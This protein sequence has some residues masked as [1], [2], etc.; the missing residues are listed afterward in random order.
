MIELNEWHTL[1]KMFRTPQDVHLAVEILKNKELSE[2]DMYRV[3][4]LIRGFDLPQEARVTKNPTW[5]LEEKM[6]KDIL[7][8]FPWSDVV[9]K[10]IEDLGVNAPLVNS[11]YITSGLGHMQ[12]FPISVR[13]TQNA[14]GQNSSGCGERCVD[15]LLGR[16]SQGSSNDEESGG[17]DTI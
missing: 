5:S 11:Q 9:T 14:S 4:F 2:L 6:K 8:H 15:A 7:S 12:S 17:P 1:R 10:G 13:S 3:L 16:Q